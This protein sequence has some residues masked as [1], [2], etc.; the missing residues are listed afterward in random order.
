MDLISIIHN[1]AIEKSIH[2]KVKECVKHTPEYVE[3][4]SNITRVV[5][6]KQ[7]KRMKRAQFFTNKQHPHNWTLIYSKQHDIRCM[8]HEHMI[9]ISKSNGLLFHK[10]QDEHLMFDADV[11]HF[12]VFVSEY[13]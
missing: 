11:E 13:Y 9:Y 7:Q 4:T 5:L 6:P 12:D 10:T 8:K 1:I 3:G 2:D